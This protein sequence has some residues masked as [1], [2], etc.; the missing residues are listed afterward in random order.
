MT[1]SVK[2]LCAVLGVLPI[3][4]FS[5]CAHLNPTVADPAGASSDARIV[6]PENF[7]HTLLARAIFEKTNR[8]RLACGVSPLAHLPAL[9]AAAEEQAFCM[10]LALDAKHDNPATREHTTADR[11]AHAG[12]PP[13]A[14]GENVLMQSARDGVSPTDPNYTYSSIAAACVSSWLGSPGHR[15]NLLDPKFTHLGCAARL[16]RVVSGETCVFA[17]QVFY[18]QP[19]KPVL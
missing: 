4:I 16:A 18:R 17:V 5:G 19:P 8:A 12:L 7:D 10:Q 1:L 11:I 6:V 3:A 15:E 2:S 14:F 13:S 9:D